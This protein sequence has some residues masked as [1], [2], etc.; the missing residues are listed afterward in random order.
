VLSVSHSRLRQEPGAYLFG[1]SYQ[2]VINRPFRPRMDAKSH[3]IAV[4]PATD[5]LPRKAPS[6]LK[7]LRNVS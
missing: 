5:R 7:I 6:R 1:S 4:L 3:P 2:K